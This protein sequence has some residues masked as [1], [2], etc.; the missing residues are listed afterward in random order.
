MK[1][2]GDSLAECAHFVSYEVISG[3]A[4]ESLQGKCMMTPLKKGSTL[5]SHASVVQ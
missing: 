5:T 2:D 1:V 3:D 4:M